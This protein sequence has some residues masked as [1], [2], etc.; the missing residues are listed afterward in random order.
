MT[1]DDFSEEEINRLKELDAER[2]IRNPTKIQN[3]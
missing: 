1:S 2:R 3:R